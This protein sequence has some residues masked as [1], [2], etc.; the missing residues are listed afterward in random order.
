MP[1]LSFS[2]S[3][4][5]FRTSLR[6]FDSSRQLALGCALGVWVGLLPKDSLLPWAILALAILTTANLVCLIAAA[7]VSHLLSPLGDPLWQEAGAAVLMAEQ[8]VPIWTTIAEWPWIAWTRFSNTVVMG[9]FAAG[10]GLSIP[11]YLGSW[12]FFHRFGSRLRERVQSHPV[13]RWIAH[14]TETE[15]GSVAGE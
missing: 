6:G 4:D 14:G 12:L 5:V 8:L 10:L 2:K 7:L 13:V 9:T 15:M 1:I 11:V 3:W